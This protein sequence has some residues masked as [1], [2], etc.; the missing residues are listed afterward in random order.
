MQAN[1]FYHLQMIKSVIHVI[2]AVLIPPEEEE[3]EEETT[4]TETVT[5]TDSV[6]TSPVEEIGSVVPDS[7]MPT[8]ETMTE[9]PSVE[10][11]PDDGVL[12]EEEEEETPD[13]PDT[14]ETPQTP[15]AA[16][17]SGSFSSVTISTIS[18]IVSMVAL[19]S[20]LA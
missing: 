4:G 8:N 3:E 14:P 17:T 12:P 13:T 20:A 2:D 10:S 5:P 1:T 11:S 19:L 9:P 18:T 15:D 16:T 7:I 6:A